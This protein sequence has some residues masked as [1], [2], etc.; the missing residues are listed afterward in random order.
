[1][2]P[3]AYIIEL[4]AQYG[5]LEAVN[6]IMQKALEEIAGLNRP[7]LKPGQIIKVFSPRSK[8]G[9]AIAALVRAEAKP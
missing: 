2:S 5:R 6:A 7:L 9:I 3:A 8:T 4:E 1:M